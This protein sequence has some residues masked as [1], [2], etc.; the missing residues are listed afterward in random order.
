MNACKQMARITRRSVCF[1]VPTI[2]III[3]TILWSQSTNFTN[4]H[5]T[6]DVLSPE[7][8]DATAADCWRLGNFTSL[9]ENQ[10]ANNSF[11]QQQC[12]NDFISEYERYCH[13]YMVPRAR[14]PQADINETVV[15]LRNESLKLC[16]CIPRVL[17]K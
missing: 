17:C 15:V 9:G 16:P 10:S 14:D 2:C 1:I 6:I 11:R 13:L 8:Y 3:T 12:V 4:S 7:V 5:V